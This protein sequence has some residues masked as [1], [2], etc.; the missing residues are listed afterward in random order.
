MRD[1]YFSMKSSWWLSYLL[2]IWV[3]KQVLRSSWPSIGQVLF[4]CLWNETESQSIHS[5][6]RKKN[7][8]KLVQDSAT[9]LACVPNHD[10]EFRSSFPLTEI[11]VQ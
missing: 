6:E 7:E 3:M 10:I 2:Y 5:Q 9:L 4:A 1:V 8:D 11:A